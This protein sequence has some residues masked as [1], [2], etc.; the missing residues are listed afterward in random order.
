MN[1]DTFLKVFDQNIQDT[2]LKPKDPSILESKAKISL[3]H[4]E[5]NFEGGFTVYENLEKVSSDRYQY[6]LPYFNFNKNLSNNFLNGLVNFSSSGENNLTDTNKLETSLIND[7][8]Y[9]GTNFFTNSGFENN[10]EINIKNLNKAGRNS[11]QY[12]SSPQIEL[13]TLYSFNSSY[14]LIKEEEDYQN[15]LI[16]KLSLK[17]NPHDM[18][19][20]SSTKKI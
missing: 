17:I 16:P 7:L 18:K 8:E 4:N 2:K 12:K 13:M 3:D 9:I 15:Y 5:Y 14:P 11:C 10:F 19:N 20:Y 6:I 1:N